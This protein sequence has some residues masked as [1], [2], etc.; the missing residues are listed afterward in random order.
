MH[1]FCCSAFCKFY[2]F[3]LTRFV[4]YF[5][6]ASVGAGSSALI[7]VWP[8]CLQGKRFFTYFTDL[9]QLIFKFLASIMLLGSSPWPVSLA[10]PMHVARGGVG[11]CTLVV[12]VGGWGGILLFA[13]LLFVLLFPTLV[14]QVPTLMQALVQGGSCSRG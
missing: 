1:F 5:A 4:S 12:C 13:L 9:G 8:F 3:I 10:L 7:V 6:L 14:L 11:G 2:G